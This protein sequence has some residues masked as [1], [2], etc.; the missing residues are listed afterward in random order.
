MPSVWSAMYEQLGQPSAQP[1]PHEVLNPQLAPVFEQIGERARTLGRIEE[2]VD[3]DTLPGQGAALARDLLA[4]SHEL[5]LAR[6]IAL[7]FGPSVGDT[8]AWLANAFA[9]GAWVRASK[10][11]V[12]MA[13]LS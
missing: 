10:V 3:R 8:T 4:Q 7:R 12:F 9:R 5:L 2:V 6:R 11:A 13:S 1:G